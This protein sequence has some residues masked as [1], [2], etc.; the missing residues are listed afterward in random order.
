MTE[1][2]ANGF[3]KYQVPIDAYGNGGF[4]FGEMSHKGSLLCLPSGMHSWAVA[5]PDQIT[6]ESLSKV[7]AEAGQI[8][9][10]FVGTGDQLLVLEKPIKQAGRDL[11]IITEPMSTGAAARTY[12]VLLGEKRAVAAALL[13]VERGK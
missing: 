3:L 12:N 11:S 9:V 7:W 5:S 2:G 8:D 13:A 1:Q 6:H 4:R 10:L